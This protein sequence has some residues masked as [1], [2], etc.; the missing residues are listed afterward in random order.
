MKIMQKKLKDLLYI[1][2]GILF[3]ENVFER[4]AEAED[5]GGIEAVRGHARRA[6]KG[7]VCAVD[8]R[9]RIQKE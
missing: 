6:H 2:V 4:V 5:G 7:I 1:L 9:I 8:Q 3:P